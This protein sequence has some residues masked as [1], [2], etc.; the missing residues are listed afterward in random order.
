VLDLRPFEFRLYNWIKRNLPRAKYNMVSS[1]LTEPKLS[2]FGVETGYDVFAQSLEDAEERFRNVVAKVYGVNREN[3]LPTAGGSEAIFLVN[4]VLFSLTRRVVVPKPNYEPMFAVPASFGYAFEDDEAALLNTSGKCV[5]LT[6]S[7]N[8]T[9]RLLSDERIKQLASSLEESCFLFVDE[10]FREFYEPSTPKTC[11]SQGKRIV[12][13]NTM[14]K[15]YGLGRLRVGWIISDYETVTILERAKRLVSGE[16]SG[17]SLWLSA[18]ILE[19]RSRFAERAKK[20][21]KENRALVEEFVERTR[22]IE[23]SD[24]DAAPFAL[25]SYNLPIDSVTLCNEVLEQTGV[26]LAPGEFFGADHAFRLCFTME[27]SVLEKGLNKLE[28]FIKGKAS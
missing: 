10:A 9:G 25:I 6:N 18:Q 17:F 27:N 2:E 16:N 5:C 19:K 15:F 4:A 14:S 8:P 1:G 13:S 22:G 12:T 11:F 21:F 20:V 7:N 28:S 3:V 26:L 23:W 24:P